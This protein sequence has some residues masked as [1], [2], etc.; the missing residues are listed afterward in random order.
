VATDDG[1]DPDNPIDRMMP[2]AD[3]PEY[4]RKL[5]VHRDAQHQAAEN[6]VLSDPAHAALGDRLTPVRQGIPQAAAPQPLP[7]TDVPPVASPVTPQEYTGLTVD[8]TLAQVQHMPVEPRLPEGAVPPAAPAAPAPVAAELP[9]TNPILAKLR[10]D[11]GIENIPVTEVKVNGHV[12]TMRVLDVGAVT[13]ALRF[14]D[15]LSMPGSP[16]ENSINL[17][18]ALTSFAISAIDGTPVW[19]VFEVDVPESELVMVEGENRPIFA[20]MSPPSNVRILGATNL[21]DFLSGQASS[22]LLAELWDKYQS[23][24]DPQGSLDSLMNSILDGEVEEPSVP[25]P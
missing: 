14:A 11:F 25:L 20:P 4:H 15:T 3:N 24:V 5:K 19:K 9:K 16:R 8:P 13:Q 10:E 7:P 18:I 17:Q 6:A 23:V 2:P 1:R 22:T 21:M 12:F